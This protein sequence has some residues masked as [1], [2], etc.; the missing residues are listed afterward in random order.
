[1]E[2]RMKFKT[3]MKGITEAGHKYEVLAIFPQRSRSIL[4]DV[5]GSVREFY[6]S[7]KVSLLGKCGLDL[8]PTKSSVTTFINIYRDGYSTGHPTLHAARMSANLGVLIVGHELT[9]ELL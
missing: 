5:D 6:P 4:A 3:G 8:I 1:M 9:V 7:G 2:I